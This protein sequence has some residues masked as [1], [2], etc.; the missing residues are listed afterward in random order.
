MA[1]TVVLMTLSARLHITEIAE[2]NK[3]HIIRTD[4]KELSNTLFIIFWMLTVDIP[5]MD[6]IFLLCIKSWNKWDE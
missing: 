6:S 3:Q 2:E 1:L 4:E 5:G